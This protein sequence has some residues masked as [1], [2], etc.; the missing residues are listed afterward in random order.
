MAEFKK[1]FPKRFD[2]KDA[3]QGVW[4]DVYDEHG[5]FYGSYK[6]C[7]FDKH[8][9]YTKLKLERYDRT[10]RKEL[11][12]QGKKPD[13]H[14]QDAHFFVHTVLMDWKV[15]DDEDN[16]IPY[17]IENAIALLSDP[18]AKFVVEFLFDCAKDVTHFK[19]QAVEED[20][21]RKAAKN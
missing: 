14:Y 10:S 3:E 2:V 19:A 18:D 9:P 4:F 5:A 6:C 13:D 8:N 17:S 16:E 15:R 20:H 21:K 12:A 1:T 11:R 7:L